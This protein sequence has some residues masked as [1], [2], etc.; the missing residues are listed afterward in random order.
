[1]SVESTSLI[2][3]AAGAGT[4]IV[5]TCVCAAAGAIGEAPA[6]ELLGGDL[7]LS[8]LGPIGQLL[9]QSVGRS[10]GRIVGG[11]AG[12]SIIRFSSMP[13]PSSQVRF[14]FGVPLDS[15]PRIFQQSGEIHASNASSGF[16]L[17]LEAESAATQQLATSTQHM[18]SALPAGT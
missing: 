12:A 16:I 9:R 6:G 15:Q 3:R 5:A 1:M 10:I 17:S 13:R 18:V 8:V 2:S 11:A 14:A 7:A 4:E